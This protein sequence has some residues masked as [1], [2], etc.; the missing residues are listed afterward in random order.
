[1]H[2]SV[3]LEKRIS[4]WFPVIRRKVLGCLGNNDS[5]DD[6]TQEIMVRLLKTKAIPKQPSSAW[7]NAVVRNASADF[8]RRQQKESRYVDSNWTVDTLGLHQDIHGEEK[9]CQAVVSEEAIEPDLIPAIA[10]ALATMR[11]PVRQA[12]LLHAH[13]HSYEEIAALTN[14]NKGTVRSRLHYAKKKAQELLE[15]YRH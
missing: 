2:S 1:M 5:A 8:W 9:Y 12:L 11:K 10:E 7:F 13:G 14:V 4:S 6:V 3:T 15:P